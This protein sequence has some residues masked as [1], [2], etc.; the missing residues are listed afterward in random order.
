MNKSLSYEISENF[1]KF[2]QN[3]TEFEPYAYS[4][5]GMFGSYCVAV[6]CGSALEAIA[7]IAYAAGEMGVEMPAEPRSDSMGHDQVLYWP[8]RLI[9]PDW[10]G[11]D[12]VDDDEGEMEDGE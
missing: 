3:N 12:E 7:E 6:N 2:I 11:E 9:D 8:G 10:F 1:A 4:G 5:R